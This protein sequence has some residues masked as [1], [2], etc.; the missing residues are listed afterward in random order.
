MSANEPRS[1]L[2]RCATAFVLVSLAATP[3]AAQPRTLRLSEADAVQRALEASPLVVRS[4][5][6]RAAA[7][8]Q[9]V[10]AAVRLPANPV[11]S[12]TIG[13]RHDV[14]GAVPP[15]T[16]TEWSLRLEQMFEIGGQRGTRLREADNAIAVAREEQRLAVTDARAE[17]RTAYVALQVARAQLEAAQHQVAIGDQLLHAAQARVRA[18]ASSDIELHLAEVERGRFEDDRLQKALEVRAAQRRLQLLLGLPSEVAVEPTEALVPAPPLHG[19]VQKLVAAALDRRGEMR[20]LRAALG[21]IDAVATRLRRERVPNPT[22]LADVAQQVPGQT[23][24]G[25]GIALPLPLWRRN[26]GEL[27]AASA[28]RS[29]LEDEQRLVRHEIELEVASAVEAV[30]TREA[31]AKLWSQQIVSAAEANVQLVQQGWLGGKL[32][33]FRVVQVARA[34]A[35][36]RQKQLEIIGELWRARIELDRAVG[37]TS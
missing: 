22:L 5:H 19:D 14:S 37:P 12:S 3:A 28:E 15:S 26:Q 1:S 16:G 29:R 31:Q 10:G 2:R 23:Y 25:G 17:A 34:A 27:A 33:L 13:Y 21:H 36:A 35:E 8:A 18:G 9:R 30:Q 4:G 11:V 6:L 24:A 7:A 32:D 20:V